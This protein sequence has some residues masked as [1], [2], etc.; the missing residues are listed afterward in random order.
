[1][2]LGIIIGLLVLISPVV[3]AKAGKKYSFPL[4]GL[5][6]ALVA[7]GIITRFATKAI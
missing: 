4:A 6:I 3:H 1:M 2:L 5:V 7:I